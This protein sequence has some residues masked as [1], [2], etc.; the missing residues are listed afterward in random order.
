ME[1]QICV[2]EMKGVKRAPLKCM[3]CDFVSCLECCKKYILEQPTTQCMNAKSVCSREWTRKFLVDNFPHHFLNTQYKKH[4]ENV[5]LQQER[6]LF[7]ETQPY[8]INQIETEKV[9]TEMSKIHHQISALNKIYSSH[10]TTYRNLC[11]R[12]VLDKQPYTRC[13]PKNGCNGFLIQHWKCGICETKFCK[14]CHQ[15][16]NQRQQTPDT[17]PNTNPDTPPNTNPDTNPLKTPT[18]NTYPP[19][20]SK[21]VFI[22]TNEDNDGLA[23]PT[24]TTTQHTCNP[25]DV[26]TAKMLE[27][28][29]KPCPNCSMGIFKIDG[30]N[31]MFCT[32][33]NTAFDWVTRKIMNGNN[34]HNPH[35]FEWL[36]NRE[37]SEHADDTAP[38][39]NNTC[40]NEG[41]TNETSLSLLRIRKFKPN[42]TE[43]QRFEIH[44]MVTICRKILHIREVVMPMYVYNYMERNRQVRISFMRNKMTEIEFKKQVQQNDKKYSKSQEIYDVYQFLINAASDI[45]LRYLDSLQKNNETTNT[46]KEIETIVKYANDCFLEISK[47]YKSKQIIVSNGL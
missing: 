26:E 24:T 34:I 8:V 10:L 32:N 9:F 38:G 11:Q 42:L 29:T 43:V 5:L 36:R 4:R 16:T 3:Y 21:N 6:A 30:C 22:D 20:E 39:V 13:C 44:E 28:N 47:T 12:S 35:Y 41:V 1:C 45:V 27:K 7:V 19:I 25:D 14:H 46:M 15:E 31:Q 18:L 33:C 37:T 2:I 17:N 23:P 40:V